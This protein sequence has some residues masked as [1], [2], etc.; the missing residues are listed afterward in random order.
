MTCWSKSHSRTNM[1]HRTTTCIRLH[2][3]L[4]LYSKTKQLMKMYVCRIV[5]NIIILCTYVQYL[6]TVSVYGF[7]YKINLLSRSKNLEFRHRTTILLNELF[8]QRTTGPPVSY[9]PSALRLRHADINQRCFLFTR[10]YC[11]P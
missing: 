1:Y 5:H 4:L 2:V 9:F 6:L 7:N 3:Y 10:R 11:L 8:L